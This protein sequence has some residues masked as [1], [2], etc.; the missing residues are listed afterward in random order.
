[1]RVSSEQYYCLHRFESKVPHALFDWCVLY[2]CSFLTIC[3]ARCKNYR[4]SVPLSPNDTDVVTKIDTPMALWVTQLSAGDYLVGRSVW[5]VIRLP[6][7]TP[8]ARPP[9]APMRCWMLMI[10]QLLISSKGPS[11]YD[12]RKILGFF[13]PLPPL[14]A[15]GNWFIP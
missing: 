14:S 11:I 13:D 1:M 10:Q 7:S 9:R 2:L 8:D 6:C 3:E 12:V 15:L 4:T 5:H